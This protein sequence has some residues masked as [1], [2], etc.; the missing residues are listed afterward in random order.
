MDA[1]PRAFREPLLIHVRPQ[2]LS[3]AVLPILRAANPV[4]PHTVSIE[5]FE[6]FA[7]ISFFK[8]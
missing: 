4:E 7:Q 3:A 1:K 8:K 6:I 5:H 2:L